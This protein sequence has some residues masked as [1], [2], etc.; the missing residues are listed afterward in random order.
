M[1]LPGGRRARDV[2]QVGW[3][4]VDWVWVHD[5]GVGVKVRR[6]L[7][8]WFF[9]RRLV[10]VI[11][12]SVL[13]V[14]FSVVVLCFVYRLVL[15]VVRLMLWSCG[16]PWPSSASSC[17]PPFSC[18]TVT[19]FAAL[20]LSPVIDTGF[21]EVGRSSWF[22]AIFVTYAYVRNLLCCSI[23][24]GVAPSFRTTLSVAIMRADAIPW[25]F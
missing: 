14:W 7:W 22:S 10:L 21:S 17:A 3:V 1:V 6:G 12:G 20:L 2:F 16:S 8:V 24:S 18:G 15:V 23:I 11:V 5:A 13:V 9:C 4:W 25:N 19:G